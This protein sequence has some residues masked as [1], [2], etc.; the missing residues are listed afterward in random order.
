MNKKFNI[1]KYKNKNSTDLFKWR[2]EKSTRNNSFKKNI[3]KL[4]EHK[5]WIKNKIK[6]KKNKIYIFYLYKKPIGMCAIFKKKSFF[7]LN[8]SLDKKFR[9]K[10][11]SKIM[12]KMFIQKIK[13]KIYKNR[14]FAIVLKKNIASY[15]QLLKLNFNVVNKES[16]YIKMKLDF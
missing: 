1:Y 16:N 12:L 14:V 8:Y 3:I 4:N 5:R 2:N 9:K 11:F 10:G 13:N 15:K 7:Y 6:Y